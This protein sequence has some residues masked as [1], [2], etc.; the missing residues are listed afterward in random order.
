MS[1]R[2]AETRDVCS[3]SDDPRSEDGAVDMDDRAWQRGVDHAG[4]EVGFCEAE[5]DRREH[6]DGH[7]GEEDAVVTAAGNG[8]S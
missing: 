6:Q 7:D 2:R 3:R 1:T 5:E 8:F 4:E